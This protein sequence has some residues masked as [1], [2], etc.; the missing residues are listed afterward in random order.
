MPTTISDYTATL[1]FDPNLYASRFIE[2]NQYL[3]LNPNNFIERQLI[4][5]KPGTPSGL[6]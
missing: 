2:I 3:S 1:T 4:I 6:P 5:T